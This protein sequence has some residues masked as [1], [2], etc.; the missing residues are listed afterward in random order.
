M[1]KIVFNEAVRADVNSTIRSFCIE[2]RT[3]SKTKGK[4][5]EE[6]TRKNDDSKIVDS[7]DDLTD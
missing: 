3:K 5:K 1:K 2:T 4:E 6:Q 7:D